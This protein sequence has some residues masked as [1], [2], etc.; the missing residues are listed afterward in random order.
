MKPGPLVVVALYW[1]FAAF[2]VLI[3]RDMGRGDDVTAV[4]LIAVG[5]GIVATIVGVIETGKRG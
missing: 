3:L 2:A 1:L 4:L 5:G